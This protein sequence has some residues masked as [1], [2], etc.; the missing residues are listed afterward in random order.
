M[1]QNEFLLL[2]YDRGNPVSAMLAHIG[3]GVFLLWIVALLCE[4]LVFKRVTEDPVIGKLC[5]AVSAWLLFLAARMA[6]GLSVPGIFRDYDLVAL[7]ILCGIALWSGIRMRE[8]IR[9]EEEQS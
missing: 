3:A 8:L 1:P 5:S 7:L 4:G 6:E 9:L 2:M